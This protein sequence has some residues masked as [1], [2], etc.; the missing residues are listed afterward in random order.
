[1]FSIPRH[2]AIWIISASQKAKNGGTRAKLVSPLWSPKSAISCCLA[3]ALLAS[4]DN[5]MALLLPVVP[6]VK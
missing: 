3:K 5:I 1:M 6:P 2:I 4:W